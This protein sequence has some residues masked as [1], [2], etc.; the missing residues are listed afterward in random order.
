EQLGRPTESLRRFLQRG[1]TSHVPGIPRDRGNP[2][3]RLR[4]RSTQTPGGNQRRRPARPGK[5]QA[6]RPGESM[7]GTRTPIE[8]F[9]A[10]VQAQRQQKQWSQDQLAEA[11]QVSR[12]TVAR[13]EAGSAVST[14]TLAKIAESLGIEVSVEIA[15]ELSTEKPSAKRP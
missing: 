4:S 13:I 10:I 5:H 11:A 8:R 15:N 9:G 14:A 6:Q 3:V 7:T 12:P 2:P 1:R